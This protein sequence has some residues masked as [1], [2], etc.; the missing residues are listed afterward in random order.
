MCHTGNTAL[1]ELD[2]ADH[3]IGN[4]KSRY[5]SAAG[6]P[7]PPLQH[8]I[9]QIQST[10]GLI[11]SYGIASS[12]EFSDVIFCELIMIPLLNQKARM[13]SLYYFF[14]ELSARNTASSLDCFSALAHYRLILPIYTD[15]FYSDFY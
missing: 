7:P 6:P 3:L 15:F 8:R 1:S 5:T 12:V 11:C 14:L 13:E 4:G 9:S 2:L 10:F